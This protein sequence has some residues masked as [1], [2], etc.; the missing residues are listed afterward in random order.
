MSAAFGPDGV[1]I[2]GA[3]HLIWE[4]VETTIDGPDWV[5]VVLTYG[6]D[7]RAFETVRRRLAAEANACPTPG[8]CGLFLHA[9][10]CPRRPSP[11]AAPGAPIQRDRTAPTIDT[12]HSDRPHHTT[13]FR[14][15]Y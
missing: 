10:E 7:R 3:G 13:A 14:G 9:P 12:D 8:R 5:A 1:R 11:L 15:N 2:D 6:P 4:G